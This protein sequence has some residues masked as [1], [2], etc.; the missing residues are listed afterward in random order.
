MLERASTCLE[1]GGRQLLRAP[2]PS[3]RTRR[4][5]HSTFWHHGA[6]DLALPSWWATPSIFGGGNGDVDDSVVRPAQEV[7]STSYDGMLLDFL[8]PKKTLA[9]LKRLSDS[10]N[11]RPVAQRRCLQGTNVRRYSTRPLATSQASSAETGQELEEAKREME[12]MLK[13]RVAIKVMYDFLDS[14]P[15]GKQ[16]LAWQIYQAIPEDHLA[17][18][19]WVMRTG[20]IKYLNEDD[21]AVMPNQILQLFDTLPKPKRRLPAYRAAI[22]AYIS[23][24]MIGPAIQLLEQVP[25]DGRHDFL[26]IGVDMVLER[27]VLDKQWPLALRVF[28]L[29]HEKK[30]MIED[31]PLHFSIR[32]GNTLPELWR[33]VAQIPDLGRYFSRLR[34]HIREF[35]HELTVTTQSKHALTDM[36]N[37]LAPHVIDHLFERKKDSDKDVNLYLNKFFKTLGELNLSS[38]SIWEHA[39]L[40]TLE[41]PRYQFYGNRS[42]LWIDGIYEEFA[43]ICRDATD[44]EQ[45]IKPSRRLFRPLIQ[46]YAQHYQLQRVEGLVADMRSFDSGMSV[47]QLKDLIHIYAEAGDAARVEEYVTEL[48]DMK[49][50]A[51][52][53]Y[54]ASALPFAYARR[55]D[56]DG[57]ITQFNRI[58]D[59]FELVPDVACWNM[60]LLAYVRADDLDGALDAFNGCLDAGLAP[61]KYSFNILL[62]LCAERGDVEAFEA[63]FS[64]AKQMG[65]PLNSDVRARSGYVQAF[66]NAGDPDGASA[67]AQGMLAS[68][69]AGVLRGHSLTHTWNLLIQHHALNQDLE[70]ARRRYKEMVTNKIPVDSWTYGSLM[71]ALV[72]VNQSNAAYRLLRKTMPAMGLRVDA[73]HY[74]ICMTGLLREGGGQLELALDTYKHM[75]ERDVPQT[76]SSREASLQLL[77]TADLRRLKKN[78][79]KNPETRLKNVEELLERI[80]VESVR[81][82]VAHRHPRHSKTL[83]APAV[84]T[85]SQHY[86][87]LLI[88]LYTT[89]SADNIIA[90]L[91]KKAEAAA[92][93]SDNYTV[94]LS[95]IEASM[96]W[97]FKQGNHAEVAR[98]WAMARKTGFALTKTVHQLT[99]PSPQDTEP[100]ALI[101]PANFQ[102]YETARI[103]NNRRHIL[104][105]SARF[106]I[107]S[108]LDPSNP[109]PKALQEAE[110]T[111]RFLLV[112]GFAASNLSWNEYIV[113]LV[114]TNQILTAYIACETF[115]I[116]GFP[117]WRE[118]HPNYIRKDQRGFS[119]ME[120][121]HYD[122]KKS[123]ILPRYKTLVMLAG[124]LKRVRREERDGE[125]YDEERGMWLREVLDEEAPRT[126]RAIQSMPRTNDGLQT[127]FLHGVG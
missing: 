64:R 18:G 11:A 27:A 1:S 2:K 30:P 75:M 86:Y 88:S 61:D 8:Y 54:I 47:G 7:K 94:P 17:R 105:K 70:G 95:L 110:H 3:L 69:N 6:S 109:N 90:K 29:L 82:Q 92:P 91:L 37:T 106:Y 126:M 79:S 97:H 12:D 62:M 4:R 85:L 117:G 40:K 56:V 10:S 57:T 116:P 38:P 26:H 67:I 100:G 53:V 46:H 50:G 16:Q 25:V 34:K 44:T 13:D 127:K 118:L 111:L 124:A 36:V 63:L 89:R 104:S 121:R 77:G 33:R 73:L 59:E 9:L 42:P 72:E 84:G 78:R 58:R 83:D 68:W 113:A 123:H 122:L 74:A 102:R 49:E 48:R 14:P 43:Q 66:L 71:R 32:Q 21:R 55:A 114:T 45:P 93:D 52:D 108:L 51:L 28:T 87:G 103:S 99:N 22:A 19:H 120:L 31:V 5:L 76:E 81:G 80:L 96:G 101:D 41:M 112:N 115:L 15:P 125:G 39:I 24:R 65:V 60:L 98:Y 20:L 35:Q 23:L 107:R 119:W